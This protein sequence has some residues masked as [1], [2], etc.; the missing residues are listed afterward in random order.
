MKT[1]LERYTELVGRVREYFQNSSGTKKSIPLKWCEACEEINLWAYWQGS[2]NAK[3]ML[4]GQDWGCPYDK[5][6]NNVMANIQAIKSGLNVSY[7]HNNNSTTNKNL[8]TLFGTL[9]YN[10]DEKQKDLFFTNFVLGYREK[11]FSGGKLREWEEASSK[12]FGELV[13]I[14]EPEIIICLGKFTLAGVLNTFGK[15]K[16][17]NNYNLFIESDENPISVTLHSEKQ[18]KIYGMAHCGAMGTMNR[19]G[20]TSCNNLDKQINDW[21]RILKDIYWR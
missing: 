14:I 20:K 9:G 11:G 10:I 19:N 12:F 17:V 8:R 1:K 16:A 5:T 2:L 3:I 4:V 6:A 18:I 15:K 21:H 7:M 13:D